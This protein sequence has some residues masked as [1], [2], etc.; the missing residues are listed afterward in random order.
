VF[1]RL[2]GGRLAP[3]LG[4]M[5]DEAANVAALPPQK[6]GDLDRKGLLL[7]SVDSLSCCPRL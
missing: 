5:L 1:E 7:Q 3:S 6:V 4:L 2:R